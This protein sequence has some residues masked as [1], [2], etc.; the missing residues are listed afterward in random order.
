MG[1][2]RVLQAHGATPALLLFILLLSVSC[3]AKSSTA[4][5]AWSP[6]S[7]P[8]TCG[9]WTI[10][11]GPTPGNYYNSL[12]SVAAVSDSTI[13]TV[14]SYANASGPQQ[15]LTEYWNGNVWKVIKSPNPISTINA[16]L[17]GVA[18]LSKNNTWAVGTYHDKSNA[19]H[20]LIEHWNGS[21]WSIVSSP[22]PNGSADQLYSVTIISASNAWAVGYYSDRLLVEHTLIEHW[23]GRQWGI[24]SSPEP[25]GSTQNHL[26]SITA[27]SAN[28]V[29]AVGSYS[30]SPKGSNIETL[31]EHWNGSSW[32]VVSSPNTQSPGNI[33]EGVTAL[34]SSNVWAVGTSFV[35]SGSP[36]RTLIEHWNGSGWSIVSSPNVASAPGDDLL[37]IAALS[38][39]NIWAV[40]R[41]DAGSRNYRTLI[42]HWNGR[43]WSLASTSIDKSTPDELLAITRV[44]GSKTVWAVGFHFSNTLSEPLIERNCTR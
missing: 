8:A 4:S 9:S 37:G 29:W 23:N 2:R 31:I 41:W 6:T 13:W 11:H 38:E 24:V 30:D 25:K 16:Q 27:V 15:T 7:T 33:L 44:P 1:K 35:Q 26:L 39:N 3:S 14:G 28:N 19:I 21:S 34:S 17:F 43:Q 5:P 36:T 12:T 42:E 22:T 40:G 10:V 18:A 20:A 32:S